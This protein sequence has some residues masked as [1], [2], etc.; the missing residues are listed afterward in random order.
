MFSQVQFSPNTSASLVMHCITVEAASSPLWLAR[1]C[2]RS[3]MHNKS[4][5]DIWWCRKILFCWFWGACRCVYRMLE[6]ISLEIPSNVKECSWFQ[7]CHTASSQ[8]T[9]RTLTLRL[10]QMQLTH[11]NQKNQFAVNIMYKHIL[12]FWPL[13]GEQCMKLNNKQVREIHHDAVWG[14]TSRWK[15]IM[16]EFVTLTYPSLTSCLFSCP[17]NMWDLQK[18]HNHDGLQQL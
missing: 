12:K 14:N 3:L 7:V 2:N 6:V 9:R 15:E 18:N 10:E 8:D 11:E 5:R 1:L 17:V 13:L 16:E 4:H